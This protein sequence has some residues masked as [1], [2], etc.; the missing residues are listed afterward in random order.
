ML[1]K[2]T[3][4]YTAALGNDR[5]WYVEGPGEGLT[6]YSGYLYNG[7]RCLSKSH[8]QQCARLAQSANNFGIKQF[9]LQFQYAIGISNIK[10][11]IENP[12]EFEFIPRQVIEPTDN[13]QKWYV[14][15]VGNEQLYNSELFGTKDSCTIAC[16][17]CHS[18]YEGGYAFARWRICDLIKVDQKR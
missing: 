10:S 15:S 11:L 17:I 18:A 1:K 7:L 4:R 9:Q 6:Y 14:T 2:N 13:N 3:T 16:A 8:A 5:K 12:R